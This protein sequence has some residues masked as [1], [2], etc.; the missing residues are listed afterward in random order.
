[1][2]ASAAEGREGEV[3][4]ARWM[5]RDAVVEVVVVVE[6]LKRMGMW[7]RVRVER[8]RARAALMVVWASIL[9]VVCVVVVIVVVGLV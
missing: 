7:V 9:G 1:M 6:E 8:A 5:T 4:V 2:A 3:E